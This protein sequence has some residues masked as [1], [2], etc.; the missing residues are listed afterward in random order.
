MEIPHRLDAAVEHENVVRFV[1]TF[2]PEA[3]R[4]LAPH[5]FHADSSRQNPLGWPYMVS[6]APRGGAHLGD[7]YHFLSQE[8]NLEVA[9]QLGRIFREVQT[10]RSWFCGHPG[11]GDETTVDGG[12][13]RFPML[14]KEN[15]DVEGDQVDWAAMLDALRD[16]KEDEGLLGR[17]LPMIQ[18]ITRR[19]PG[20][21]PT[22]PSADDSS[23][24]C[25]RNENLGQP[26]NIWVKFGDGDDDGI[27]VDEDGVRAV[28]EPRITA[29][30]DWDSTA[31]EP[32]FA[33]CRPPAWLWAFP[34]PQESEQ[35]EQSTLTV[36]NLPRKAQL[37]DVRA[38]FSQFGRVTRVFGDAYSYV[39]VSLA[40]PEAAAEAIRQTNGLCLGLQAPSL[41]PHPHDAVG[42]FFEPPPPPP[43]PEDE[44]KRGPA[45][46]GQARL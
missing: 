17:A 23:H 7:A 29:I 11:M 42:G 37:S 3:V 28:G 22:S 33:G 10:A 38:A 9:A 4:G 46:R 31:F 2:T 35:I 43:T 13:K 39:H 32:R 14:N 45:G 26:S 24:I 44:T 12:I 6:K 16:P 41:H 18:Y 8:Q 15:A 36:F 5:I 21:I 1:G 25:L 20:V 30:R 19:N 40:S 34:D 27:V